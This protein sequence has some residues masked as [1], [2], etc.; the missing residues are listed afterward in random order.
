MLSIGDGTFVLAIAAQA[1]HVGIDNLI[2][3]KPMEFWRKNMPQ[4]MLLR[5][6]CDWHLAP[7][8]IHTIEKFL[9]SR[10]QTSHD[11]EPLSL[12]FYLS[13]AEWFQTQKQITTLPLHIQRLDHAKNVLAR[14]A[15]ANTIHA[16]KVALAPG[17][18]RCASNPVEVKSRWPGGRYSHAGEV[19]DDASAA[20]KRYLIIGG[21]QSAVEWPARLL[22]GGAS[23]I[24]V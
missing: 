19:A 22:G 13:Y 5:S 7:V 4:G 11:V 2:V 8:N 24:Y 14:T 18:K 6:A 9:E 10:G 16:N 15:G 12:D 17:F 20:K 21:R 3:G 1:T 23:R